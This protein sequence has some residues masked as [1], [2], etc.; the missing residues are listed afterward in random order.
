MVV[1]IH[2]IITSNKIISNLMKPLGSNYDRK[3]NSK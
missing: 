3:K 1:D 2:K